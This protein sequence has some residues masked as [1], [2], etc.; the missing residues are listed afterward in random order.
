[1]SPLSTTRAW[2]SGGVIAA[3]KVLVEDRLCP[4]AASVVEINTFLQGRLA[5]FGLDCVAAVNAASWLNEAGLLGDSPSRPGKPLRDL[6]RAGKIK[7][8]EQRP[9]AANDR[10]FVLSSPSGTPQPLPTKAVIGERIAH[11]AH[12]AAVGLATGRRL[13]TPEEFRRALLAL[14]REPAVSAARDWPRGLRDL[15]LCGLYSWWVDS[16]GADQLS[17]GLGVPIRGGRIY[18]GQTGAT[19]WP[20]GRRGSQTLATRIGRNHLHGSIRGSTFRMTLA[21]CL[22]TPLSLTKIGKKRLDPASEL[23]LTAWMKQHLAVAVFGFADPD[24]LGNLEHLV[25]TELD[26]PLN[27]AGMAETTTRVALSRKRA[28]VT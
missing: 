14:D 4:V 8:A 28:L 25:L 26:P 24:P 22:A 15:A 3:V 16:A 7:N 6:L 20:S 12:V 23:R 10:W 5:T 11:P 18:A 9:P 17:D 19:K 21:A 2:P 1:M 27:L 13:C